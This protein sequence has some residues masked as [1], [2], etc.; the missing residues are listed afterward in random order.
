MEIKGKV[1]LL[2]GASRGIGPV[3]AEAFARRGAIIALT[4]RSQQGLEVTAKHLINL[5]AKV[6]IFPADLRESSQRENLIDAVLRKLGRI[7][8]LINNAG[9]ESEGKYLELP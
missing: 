7:D 1:V 2:T 4:A 3:L 5:N 9:L 8:V 6:H